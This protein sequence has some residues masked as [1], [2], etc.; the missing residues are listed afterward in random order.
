VRSGGPVP[1]GIGPDPRER[2]DQDLV[3]PRVDLLLGPEEAREVLHPL[4]V[5]HGDAAGVRDHVG[6]HRDAAVAQDQVCLGQGR[7]VGALQDHPRAQVTRALRGQHAFQRGRDQHVGLDLPERLGLDRVGAGKARDTA[8]GLGKRD[9]RSHV[10]ALRGVHGAA[11]VLD[12]D[13][14]CAVRRIQ[15]GRRRADVAEALDRD[16]RALDRQL[17]AARRL[18]ADHEH[19]AAGG[20]DAPERAAERDRLAGDDAGGGGPD[21]HRVGV[22]HPG[23]HLGVGVDVRRGDVL[24][25]ADDDADLAGVAAR[26]PLELLHREPRRF[27]PDAALGAAIGQ[28]HRRVL[29]RH[30]GGQR[31]HLL[32]RHVGVVAHAALAGAARQVVLDAKA[33]EVRDRAVVHLDRDVDDQT[34]FGALERLDPAFE[35]TEVGAHPLDLV[36][37]GGPGAVRR[38]AGSV[39]QGGHRGSSWGAADHR[40]GQARSCLRK[41]TITDS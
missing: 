29:D 4:E 32:E 19:A 28:V 33:L 13:H 31:H 26:D 1:L 7:A 9:Q 5:R 6:H 38:V 17:Q 27:A 23:H 14:A 30:P 16:A 22:H 10:E 8:V 20:L 36:E 24:H 40:D 21:V 34:A 11:G 39:G 37:V 41:L 3:E 18:A 15:L 25:R 2:T 12:R 35:R